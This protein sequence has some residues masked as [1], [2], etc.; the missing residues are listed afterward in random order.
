MQLSETNLTVYLWNNHA[1]FLQVKL[2]F[3]TFLKPAKR[4]W[5]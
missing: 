4:T 5:Q 2:F 3:A 1:C